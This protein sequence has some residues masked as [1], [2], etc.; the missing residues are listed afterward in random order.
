MQNAYYQGF[1]I[2]VPFSLRTN[3]RTSTLEKSLDRNRRLTSTAKDRNIGGWSFSVARCISTATPHAGNISSLI[4]S[5]TVVIFSKSYCPYC[6]ATKKVFQE[7]QVD[8]IVLIELDKDP[9]GSEMQAELRRMTG[10]ST[11]PN[12]FVRGQ[13]LG[14]NNDIQAA[15]KSGKLHEMLQ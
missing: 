6:S 3:V 7:L 15:L 2:V 12:V 5:N 9:Q 1:S 11:V 10:Q 14:G 13:H 4:E 8:D